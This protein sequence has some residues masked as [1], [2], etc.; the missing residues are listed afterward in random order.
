MSNKLNF[1]FIFILFFSFLFHAKAEIKIF[2]VKSLTNPKNCDGSISVLIDGN[3]G[4]Y[5][6]TAIL[7]GKTT[8]AQNFKD[9][10]NGLYTFDSLCE[11]DYEISVTN[12]DGKIGGTTACTKIL[13]AKII[14]CTPFD[15]IVEDKSKIVCNDDKTGFI[16]ISVQ[17]GTSPY[18]YSWSSG[19]TTQDVYN[20]EGNRVYNVTITDANGCKSDK[21]IKIEGQSI[22]VNLG[23]TGATSGK[24]DGT[25]FV[26]GI[27]IISNS[28]TSDFKYLWSNGKTTK[29]ITDLCGGLYKVTVTSAEGCTKSA[30]INVIQCSSKP[31]TL[32][33]FSPSLSYDK[34]LSYC[35]ENKN[36]EFYIY[37]E[38]GTLP[39]KYSFKRP[40]G[41]M[42][43]S[44]IITK[45]YGNKFAKIALLKKY[46]SQNQGDYTFS[47][48]DACGQKQEYV[49]K[50][51]CSDSK[52]LFECNIDL[53][54]ECLFW[55][56]H[57]NNIEYLPKEN[58][59]NCDYG[60]DNRKY[61][62]NWSHLSKKNKL[63]DGTIDIVKKKNS[64]NNTFYNEVTLK[65][66]T[67]VYIPEPDDFELSRWTITDDYGCE[68][69][70]NCYTL[71]PKTISYVTSNIVKKIVPA[72]DLTGILKQYANLTVV[73]ED[74]IAN[75]QGA[76]YTDCK[77]PIG[78]EKESFTRPFKYTPYSNVEPCVSGYF[79]DPYGKFV[80]LYGG[81]P[82]FKEDNSKCEVEC[83]CLFPPGVADKAPY[84]NLADPILI[85]TTKKTNPA[86]NGVD[87]SN[88][89]PDPVDVVGFTHFTSDKDCPNE[90]LT[91]V[92]KG[93]CKYDLICPS[94]GKV[95]IKDEYLPNHCI[96]GIFDPKKCELINDICET[97]C[98][99]S[100]F[101][102]FDVARYCDINEFCGKNNPAIVKKDIL[103]IGYKLGQKPQKG[104]AV[105]ISYDYKNPLSGYTENIKA[106]FPK[107]FFGPNT[108][109]FKVSKGVN[110]SDGVV[111]ATI[112][113]NPF[114]NFL[115]ITVEVPNTSKTRLVL[116]NVLG[117]I[118]QQEQVEVSK[119]SN[120]LDFPL[121]QNL[122][123]GLYYL[124]IIGEDYKL[125]Y[126][127][128]HQ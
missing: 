68:I 21:S 27:G 67:K 107:A 95:I 72:N 53:T 26:A 63:A 1:Y 13:N 56:Q 80:E 31:I 111:F 51:N 64:N 55:V 118:I 81:T 71:E 114:E 19:Q 90:N 86:P 120:S 77:N 48:E 113:P 66:D 92:D 54:Y 38:G 82:F 79:K 30:E 50:C 5:D 37:V 15:I 97:T 65:K 9:K 23:M 100:G 98:D 99:V 127:I 33:S 45:Y 40:N 36:N 123:K 89:T 91:E 25:A 128:V 49:Y 78:C 112:Y 43:Q 87:C 126:P 69:L 58:P 39:I 24:C 7:N 12:K 102:R 14:V 41:G 75:V 122:P 3:S 16:D 73:N 93:N 125:Q 121:N 110:L 34:Q 42:I 105:N 46:D 117:S 8:I 88:A 62:I 74:L 96:I 32:E 11:G 108:E 6:I 76:S 119:G 84:K 60:I 52:K 85:K 47:V 115:K 109:N 59:E 116:V 101:T 57:S 29:S 35:N 61:T 104:D 28:T 83:Y 18:K 103:P 106:C 94:T 2:E 20:L 17:G 10:G 70:D 124:Q 44:G 22:Q 4:P